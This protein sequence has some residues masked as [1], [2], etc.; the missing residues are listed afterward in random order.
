MIGVILVGHGNIATGFESGLKL[1]FGSASNFG[2]L[3]FTQDITP[4]ILEQK[5]VEKIEELNQ[6]EGILI[7][8]DIAGGTPF[9]TA[10]MLS[11]K[12]ENVKVVSGMNFSMILEVMSERDSFNINELYTHAI[13]TG[14]EEIRGFEIV[15]KEKIENI[16]DDGI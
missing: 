4:E 2:A 14:K 16:E 3:D 12:Y 6:E 5:I 9:K 1:V 10:S 11:M 8:S 15:K 7:L 13:N